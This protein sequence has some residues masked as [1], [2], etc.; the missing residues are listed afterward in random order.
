M[1]AQ[2]SFTPETA[3]REL[4]DLKADTQSDKTARDQ[5]IKLGGDLQHMARLEHKPIKLI[6]GEARSKFELL[7][8]DFE[9]QEKP[10]NRITAAELATA[11]YDM[12]YLIDNVL[13]RDQPAGLVGPKK[14]LKTNISIDLAVSRATGG[15]FLGYYNV[16]QPCHVAVMSGESGMATI[17][18]TALR[19]CEAAGVWLDSTDIIFSDT[20]PRFGDVLNLEAFRKFLEYDGIE[21]VV[22]DPAYLCLPGDVNAANLFDVG[23][24]LRNVND[25]CASAGSTLVLAHHLKKGVIN[26]YAPGQLEDIGWAGFQEFFRQWLLINRRGPYEPGSGTHRLWFSTGGSAGHSTQIGLNIFEGVFD[27]TGQTP[28][29]WDVSIVKTRDV[30]RES[31][32]RRAE[33]KEERE[34]IKSQE[35]LKRDM[36]RVKAFLQERPDG[37]TV[38][39]I[40]NTT[41]ISRE[42]GRVALAA[43]ADSDA[44][45]QCKFTKG[46]SKREW[47][48]FKMSQKYRD[49]RDKVSGQCSPH[50]R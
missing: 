27:P 37:D 38:T 48:G 4:P 44:I 31:E 24:V 14:S 33:V 20:L 18:E 47:D 26:P 40:T 36:E 41:G 35:R 17:Q 1:I 10:F 21:V 28:R 12:T 3:Q 19:V 46:N 25:I 7:A 9:H 50:S 8:G 15:R 23:R 5:L 43:L 6:V 13:V 11:H 30:I 32:Q 45:E 49:D 22:V 34:Q 42:R 39:A 16:P 29:K 2:S